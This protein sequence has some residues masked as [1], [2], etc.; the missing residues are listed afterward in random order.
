VDYSLR[1][2]AESASN[3]A[4]DLCT[5]G[6]GY[7][8]VDGAIAHTL[9]FLDPLSVAGPGGDDRALQEGIAGS[10]E[11]CPS[12][13]SRKDNVWVGQH[14]PR[15][16]PD[17]Q[18]QGRS[19]AAR[20][21]PV[22]AR[23]RRLGWLVVVCAM[24]VAVAACGDGGRVPRSTSTTASAGGT[25]ATSGGSFP[26]TYLTGALD[27]IQ[28][29]AFYADRVD[30]PTVRAEARRR[31][32]AATT[33]AGTYDAIRW[34]LTRLGDRH[35]FLLSPEQA[36]DL[37]AGSGRSFG[38]L[39]LFPERVVIDVE[40]GGAADR[41]GVRVGDVVQAVDG[42]PVR[43]DRIVTLPSAM[44]R[45][46]PARVALT[47]RRGHGGDSRRLQVTVEA[48]APPAVRS[49]AAR[50]V[51]ARVSL[52]ELFGVINALG[53]NASRYVEPAHDAIRRVDTTRTCG[54][55]V[56]LRRNTGGSLP[57]M[58]AAVGPI[59]GD[60]NAVGYRTRGGA[61]TWFGYKDGAVTADGRPDRSL[62][63]ARRPA[64]LGRPAPPVAVLTS[65]LTASSGEG[66][67]IAFRGRSRTR[68]FG[69][70]TAGVPTGNSP[71]RLSDGAEL[72]LTEAVGVDRTGR[73]YHTPHQ[74]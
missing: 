62:A 39:A 74:A 38:L 9:E 67:A 37:S 30:W 48:A 47:L 57:P 23:R 7:T 28:G 31:A 60:G 15:L 17:H 22:K 46:G 32:G 43:G 51:S 72:H 2:L 70:P 16:L 4:I 56:D 5:A 25:A 68:S 8:R 71:H 59:L 1:K 69:E 11:R 20:A 50:R 44:D 61:I 21:G 29:N 45:N 36:R 27:L 18:P 10:A 53:P 42:R 35:S 33:T 58:L 12:G 24:L 34:V 13:G 55:V 41:A 65:R 63:A 3:T 14:T 26:E 52:L 54:W 19:V 64:R 6:D 40:P 49:P 66:V 73:S